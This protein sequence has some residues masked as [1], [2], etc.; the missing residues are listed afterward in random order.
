MMGIILFLAFIFH[1]YFFELIL[2][3]MMGYY[4]GQYLQE[5]RKFLL[6]LMMTLIIFLAI[7]IDPLISEI[8]PAPRTLELSIFMN[9]LLGCGFFTGFLLG[10]LSRAAKMR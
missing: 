4:I 3:T 9:T 2:F 6:I 5:K 10:S 8:L 1:N 7:F